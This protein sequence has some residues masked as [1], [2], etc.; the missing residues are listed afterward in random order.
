LSKPASDDVAATILN[1]DNI[2]DAVDEACDGSYI[3]EL[4]DIRDTAIAVNRRSM[5][6]GIKAQ[7]QEIRR[8]AEQQVEELLEQSELAEPLGASP[9]SSAPARR[10]SKMGRQRG[11]ADRRPGRQGSGMGAPRLEGLYNLARGKLKGSFVEKDAAHPLFQEI[12]FGY[13]VASGELAL[14][15]NMTDADRDY[16]TARCSAKPRR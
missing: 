9:Q 5:D 11:Y 7:L 16:V 3:G 8:R 2:C 6:R 14:P 1:F 4:I 10:Q 15:E 13:S 12:Q